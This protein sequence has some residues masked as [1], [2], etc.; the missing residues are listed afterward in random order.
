MVENSYSEVSEQSWVSRLGQSFKSVLIGL[1]LFVAAFPVLVWNEGRALRQLRA[2]HEGAALVIDVPSDAV[3]PENE[4][5][6][7]HLSGDANINETLTDPEFGI[8]IAAIKLMRQVEMFQWKEETSSQT[9]NKLGGG[10][11]TATTYTYVKDWSPRL[12]DSSR[13]HRPEGHSNPSVM[14]VSSESWQARQIT[15]GRFDLSSALVSK[16]NRLER[17]AIDQTSVD[18]LPSSMKERARFGGDFYYLGND[19]A[20]PAIGDARVSFQAV[21]PALVSVVARQ[22]GNTLTGYEAKAGNAIL[23]LDY[24]V[25][26]AQEMFHSAETKNRELTWI[27]RGLGFVMLALGLFLILR[28]LAVLGTVI[29]ILGELVGIGVGMIAVVSA[30]SLWLVTIAISWFAVRPILSIC[31]L[32]G[33][34]CIV[35]L[36]VRRKTRHQPTQM[37]RTV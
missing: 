11:E 5:K 17:L 19:P 26:D 36:I 16:M 27:F 23:L 18:K 32:L 34:G 8:S 1:L 30:A 6:L 28:P 12:I 22:E 29:P 15:L 20:S 25:V 2:F 3:R 31:L 24:G 4:G 21:K 35:W 33:A 13:F 9:H 7:I 37:P 10:K 14:P